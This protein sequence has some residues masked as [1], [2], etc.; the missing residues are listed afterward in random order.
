MNA[1]QKHAVGDVA[2]FLWGLVWPLLLG[3]VLGVG[4]CWLLQRRRLAWT[5][6]LLGYP[7]TYCLWFLERRIGVIV[8]AA[9]ITATYLG[10]TIHGELTQ[11]GGEEARA[12]RQRRGPLTFV[13]T[14]IRR[15][16]ARSARR[17][18]TEGL[19]IGPSRG[20]R[21]CRIPFGL[22]D[23]VH[24]LIAGATGSGKT[25]TQAAI[26]EAYVDAGLSA[27]VIDPKGD[28]DLRTTLEAAAR[29]RG[30][31]FRIWTPTGPSVYNPLGRGGPT[32]IVDKALS[33][34][35][36]SEPHYELA[37]QRLLGHVLA[38]MQAIGEWPPTLSGVVA[39]MD[40]EALD[41]KADKAGG[42]LA[43]RVS[44][45]VDSRTSKSSADLGGGRDRLAVLAES[46]LGPWL[47]PSLGDGP[48]LDL[49]QSVLTGEVLYFHLDADRY[50][51]ASKLLAAALMIDLVGL[52]S[53][54]R[55]S[56]L[57]ALLVVDEFAALAAEQVS[58]LFAR[59]RSAGLSLLLGTQSLADLRGARPDD[60]S[61]T[62]T[63]QVLSNVE[64]TLAHRIGDP[65]SAERLA[66]LAGT[67]PSWTTT[68]RTSGRLFP[69][70][71]GEGTRT[72]EREFL[73]GPDEFK[74]LRTGEAVAIQPRT[75]HPAEI[76]SVW[77]PR[78]GEG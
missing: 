53:E 75:A 41:A 57:G 21:V 29:R 64:F 46:E 74:R 23:G 68:H 66:R 10:L 3:A 32:E 18:T 36:W 49:H 38:T 62:L 37:T 14:A 11:A 25:V 60:P 15:R 77:P 40:P 63:E 73:I 8:L 45:Y 69:M 50:P 59:A 7:A 22:G 24:G 27:I 65:D 30:V 16:R 56:K 26:A 44:A 55:H 42:A 58:R 52:T 54:A 6:T 5:W 61:D 76:V 13:R 51:A 20:G 72:R 78:R 4:V 71:T 33:A 19:A 43:E 2:A 34:H 28:E 1:S 31:N 9:T 47:D 39:N 67:A 12:A 70:Q 35:R 48:L 17:L